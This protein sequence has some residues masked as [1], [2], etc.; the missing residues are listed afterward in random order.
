DLD[1]TVARIR[2]I[3]GRKI[4]RPALAQ[5]GDLDPIATDTSVDQDGAYRFGA[6]HRQ[7]VVVA[8]RSFMIRMADDDHPLRLGTSQLACEASHGNCRL[9][10]QMGFVVTEMKGVLR[11]AQ[12]RVGVRLQRR[13]SSRHYS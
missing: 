12:R 11:N 2:S 10:P 5:A 13:G 1:A 4:Q 6:A 3:A 8:A 7:G 9:A